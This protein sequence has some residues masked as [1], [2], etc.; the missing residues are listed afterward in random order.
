MSLDNSLNKDT[1]ESVNVNC[2]ATE[3][4]SKD[5]PQKCSLDTPKQAASAYYQ[6]FMHVAPTSKRIIQD[7]ART[8]NCLKWIRASK[9]ALVDD[10]QLREKYNVDP[11]SLRNGHR[12]DSALSA[13][14]P[15]KRG[16]ARKR[17][18]ATDNYGSMTHLHIQA[19][20][21][22]DLKMKMSKYLHYNKD[23]HDTYWQQ[24]VEAMQQVAVKKKWAEKIQEVIYSR[25]DES[26]HDGLVF[27]D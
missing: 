9:G 21:A 6:V 2:A 3:F 12:R 17:K 24:M 22:V 20:Q 13:L 26:A 5:S 8:V 19:Q 15:R 25:S 10:K 14:Q 4:L 23:N 18:L 11:I 27:P 16:G 7:R 1:H